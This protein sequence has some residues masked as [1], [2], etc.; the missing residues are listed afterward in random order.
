MKSEL[1]R[2]S[3]LLMML[4]L[5]IAL[6]TAD[7]HADDDNGGGTGGGS[8]SGSGS[9]GSGGGSDDHDGGDDGKNDGGDDSGK[10][11]GDGDSGKDEDGDN[12]SEIG[13]TGSQEAAAAKNAVLEGQAKPLTDLFSF[14]QQ[15][16]PGQI[17]DVDLKQH[18]GKFEY[19]LKILQDTGKVIKL[20]LDAMTLALR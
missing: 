17:L 4:G 2:R 13:E 15:N 18:S 14:L 12:D 5:A 10:D 7:A 6:P 9:S 3:L 1:S 16:Y 19:R 11:D 20:R 8:G